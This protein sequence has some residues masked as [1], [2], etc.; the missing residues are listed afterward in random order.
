[1]EEKWE[2]ICGITQ[3]ELEEYFDGNIV[4]LGEKQGWTHE[5]TMAKLRERYDGYHFSPALTDIYNPFSILNAFSDLML[6]DYWFNSA[7]PSALIE[8]LRHYPFS[9]DNLE[10]VVIPQDGFDQPFDNFS[11]AIPILYKSGYLTIK[12]YDRDMREY[13]I[14][15][16]N[17]E[18]RSGLYDTLL[19]NYVN[20]DTSLN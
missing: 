8:T 17:G 12:D 6:K 9:I 7:T 1:M 11:T 3:S 5:Q 19:D 18:V 14:G 13:T 15:I 2:S 20:A 10:G 4:E 16:P